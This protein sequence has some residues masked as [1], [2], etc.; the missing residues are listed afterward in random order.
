MFSCSEGRSYAAAEGGRD[1]GLYCDT[2][3]GGRMGVVSQCGKANYSVGFIKN[4]W[5]P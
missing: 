4:K 5:I 1:S 2:L 3:H